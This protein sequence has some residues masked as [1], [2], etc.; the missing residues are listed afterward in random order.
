[1]TAGFDK[2]EHQIAREGLTNLR[3]NEKF[4]NIWEVQCHV[5]DCGG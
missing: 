5:D 4:V 3:T 1:M 2:I